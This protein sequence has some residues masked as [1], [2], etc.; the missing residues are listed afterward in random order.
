[1][2]CGGV[3]VSSDRHN[4]VPGGDSRYAGI[5]ISYAGQVVSPEN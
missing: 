4:P 3:W 1:M 5:G 2:G